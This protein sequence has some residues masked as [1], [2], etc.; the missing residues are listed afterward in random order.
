[1]GHKMMDNEKEEQKEEGGQKG[2]AGMPW[3]GRRA[4]QT[5]PLIIYKKVTWLSLKRRNEVRQSK[6]EF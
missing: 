4:S 5:T 2:G 3:L 1:M 6:R